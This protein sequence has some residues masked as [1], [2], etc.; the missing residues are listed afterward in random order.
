MKQTVF[1][2]V[3]AII[4]LLFIVLQLNVNSRDI[5]QEETNDSLSKAVETT[6]KNVLNEGDYTFDEMEEFVM[7]CTQSLAKNMTTNSEFL[8]N[9]IEADKDR[10]VA[11]LEVIEVK[12]K[13]ITKCLKSVVFEDKTVL[14]KENYRINFFIAEG[15]EH[16]YKSYKVTDGNTYVTPNTLPA[17]T[18]E[19][20]KRLVG[21]RSSEGDMVG[22][23]EHLTPT[24]D[25][26]YF[27]VLN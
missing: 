15:D 11:S 25:R 20:E 14:S 19:P 1:G 27:A 16:P 10:G 4:S 12:N 23:F 26:D 7:D 17:G 24:E 2:F 6:M 18:V 5:R 13:N 22:L 21:W 3:V 8:I 9:V